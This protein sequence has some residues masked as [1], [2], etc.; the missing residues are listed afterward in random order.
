MAN[1]LCTK[2][3][4][5]KTLLRSLDVGLLSKEEKAREGVYVGGSFGLHFNR[6]VSRMCDGQISRGR[7]RSARKV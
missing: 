6:G 1:R 5:C 4:K 2:S 7:L 3:T